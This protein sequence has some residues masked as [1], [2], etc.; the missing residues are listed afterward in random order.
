MK[1]FFYVALTLACSGTAASEFRAQAQASSGS[2]SQRAANP[3]APSANAQKPSPAQQANPFPTDSNSVPVLPSADSSGTSEPAA[4][5]ADRTI[6]PLPSGDSDPVRSPDDPASASGSSEASDSSSSS[7][8]LDQLLKPPP[9][10][11]RSAKK[12]DADAA[13]QEGPKEDENVGSYYLDQKNWKAAFSRFE[14]ALVLD[15]ENPDVYWGL[16]EAER[17]LGNYANAKAHYQKLLDYDPDSK[18]GKEARKILKEP[19]LANAPAVSSN[20]H[21][22]PSQH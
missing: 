4:D 16:A 20:S 19:E 18:H 3:P 11:G 15:P 17:H 8:G 6:I 13:P 2:P 22:A 7:E 10:T 1:R 9:E 5:A 21:S 14:S 12:Q